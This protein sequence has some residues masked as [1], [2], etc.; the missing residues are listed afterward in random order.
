MA[1]LLHMDHHKYPWTDGS[2]ANVDANQ[3]WRTDARR[4]RNSTNGSDAT[5]ARENQEAKFPDGTYYIHI[6]SGDQVHESIT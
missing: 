1:K 3:L 5:R 6:I 4:H 2:T